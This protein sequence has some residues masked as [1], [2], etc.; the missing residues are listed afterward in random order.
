MKLNV[1]YMKSET[2]KKKGFYRY[3]NKKMEKEF[4]VEVKGSKARFQNDI[5]F[6]PISELPGFWKLI[7]ERVKKVT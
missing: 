3:V 5:G 4:I 6:Y 2:P 1:D 7:E